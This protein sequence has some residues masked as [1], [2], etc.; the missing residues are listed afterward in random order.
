V[1]LVGAHER[2]RP[3]DPTHADSVRQTHHRDEATSLAYAAADRLDLDVLITDTRPAEQAAS[4]YEQLAQ[5]GHPH[6]C[7]A[8]DWSS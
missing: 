5:P 1:T 4:V 2:L 6:L 3:A 7:I 8:L